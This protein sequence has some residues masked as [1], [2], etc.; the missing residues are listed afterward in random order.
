MIKHKTR[1]RKKRVGKYEY[2]YMMPVCTKQVCHLNPT[3]LLAQLHLMKRS[4][5]EYKY[6]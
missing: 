1:K 4:G 3:N 5:S 6:K 2:V